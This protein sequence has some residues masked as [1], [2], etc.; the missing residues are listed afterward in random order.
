MLDQ[1]YV[2]DDSASSFNL[3]IPEIIAIDPSEVFILLDGIEHTQINQTF[4]IDNK[5]EELLGEYILNLTLIDLDGFK[6]EYEFKVEFRKKDT[7]LIGIIIPIEEF[8]NLGGEESL[9]SSWS[10]ELREPIEM[11]PEKFT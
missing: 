11:V 2:I 10:Y 3:T 5:G 7:S 9:N 4:I 8:P 1:T 6:S